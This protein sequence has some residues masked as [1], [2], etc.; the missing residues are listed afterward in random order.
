MNRIR[1]LL[2]LILT[3]F[4]ISCSITKEQKQ[5]TVSPKNFHHK[6]E[7]TLYKSLIL[8]PSSINSETKNFIFDTGSELSI[9][10]SDSLFEKN[11]NVSGASGKK[12]KM[13]AGKVKSLRIGNVEF[14]NTNVRFSDLSEL[15]DRIPDFG[16][17]IGQSIIGKS[18]WLID[19]PNKKLEIS[20]NDI[21]DKTFSRL[22]I[23]RKSGSP[24]TFISINGKKYKAIIDLGSTRA[25]SIPKDSE[26]AKDLL[27]TYEFNDI[28]KDNFTIGGGI[29]KVN[30][31][32]G[33][34][35]VIEL[36]NTKIIDVETVIKETTQI[37]IGSGFFKN[38]I[39]YID[40]TNEEY[41][42][43]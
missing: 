43:K 5:G 16:G 21:S 26:L 9:I 23:V 35:P 38:Y 42:L 6:T 11:Y 34:L 41:K 4:L 24:F 36:G 31:K 39:L 1:I 2:T 13:G 29:E 19:Y 25:L 30:Q 3:S 10:N 8:I 22:E 32:I 18:N 20:N 14:E 28:E 12:M 40:N 7:F 33:N 37:R 17:L 27:M 15:E